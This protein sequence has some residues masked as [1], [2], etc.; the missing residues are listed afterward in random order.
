MANK[1]TDPG[2]GRPLTPL[3]IISLFLTL[4]ETVLGV[5][6]IRTEGGVQIALTA[7][8]VAFPLL[9]A[10]AFFTI[11]WTRPWVFYAP[12]E[13][14][15][16]DPALFVGTLAHARIRVITKTADLPQDVKVIGNP[17]QFVLLFK[18]AGTTW[19]KSTKAMDVGTGCILQVTTEQ[20]SA[21]GS[22]SV[23]EAVTFVPGTT[24]GD[25]GGGS[26]KHLVS[27]ERLQ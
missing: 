16:V 10:A 25:D 21:D 13:Y 23:A 18:A 5:A 2:K 19:K 20:L 6:V 27:N 3:W 11:L 8:V 7:F 17:D 15:S 24:I 9:V 14:G 12:T 26:G 1:T 22:L 4:T